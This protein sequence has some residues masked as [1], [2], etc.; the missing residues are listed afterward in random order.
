[1]VQTVQDNTVTSY[2]VKFSAFNEPTAQNSYVG[3]GD[4]FV[5]KFNNA[6]TDL[7]SGVVFGGTGTS[8]GTALAIDQQNYIYVTGATNATDFPAVTNTNVYPNNGFQTNKGEYD[9]F[10]VKL[11]KQY[12][13]NIRRSSIVGRISKRCR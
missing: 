1:M 4:V 6:L 9:A 2:P 5:T 12:L 8:Y 10:V 3:N 7:T 13:E 11:S